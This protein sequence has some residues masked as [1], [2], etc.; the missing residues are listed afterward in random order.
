MRR[1]AGRTPERGREATAPSNIRIIKEVHGGEVMP[2]DGG[3]VR[4]KNVQMKPFFP[5]GKL[6]AKLSIRVLGRTVRSNG[7]PSGHTDLHRRHPGIEQDFAKGV[8]IIKV[9]STSFRPEMVKDEATEDVEGLAGVSEAASV[10]REEAGGVVFVF[11]GDFTEKHERPGGREVSVGFPFGPNAF[12]GFP[13]D[14]GP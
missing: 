12:V 2:F 4:S 7:L 5:K 1:V 3:I 14:L 13:D 9:F 8:L 10:I 6:N 11:Q